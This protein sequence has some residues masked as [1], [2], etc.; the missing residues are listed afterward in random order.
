M[1]DKDKVSGD[2]LRELDELKKLGEIDIADI[3]ITANVFGTFYCC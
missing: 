2:V 1:K 3:E